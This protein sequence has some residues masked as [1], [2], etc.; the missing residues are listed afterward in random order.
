MLQNYHKQIIIDFVMKKNRNGIQKGQRIPG[1]G[2]KPGAPNKA[3]RLAR[4][5]IAEFVDGNADRLSQWLDEI[6]AAD[7]PKDAFNCFTALLEYHV[8]KLA[9]TEHVGDDGGPIEQSLTVKF[10]R[11]D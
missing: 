3:T 11:P 5:A 6:Y 8:P 2:R 10:V 7:G 9:R 1:S 4:E